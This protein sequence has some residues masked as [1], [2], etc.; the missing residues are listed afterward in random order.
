M[1]SSSLIKRAW[2]RTFK[3]RP[4][5]ALPDQ[6]LWWLGIDPRKVAKALRP[7]GIRS[8]TY[9]RNI[10]SEP[11]E[12]PAW[13]PS[14]DDALR[15]VISIESESVESQVIDAYPSVAASWRHEISRIAGAIE[16]VLDEVKPEI[17]LLVQ[18]Y[19]PANAIARSWAIRNECR[20]V[21]I[22]NTALQT[23]MVW[24]DVSGITTNRN[25]AANLFWRYKGYLTEGEEERFRGQVLAKVRD[26]K[27]D[28]HTAPRSQIAGLSRQ[29][30][31]LFLAQ[32]YTDSSVVF[33]LAEWEDPLQ[34][35]SAL[36]DWCREREFGLVIKLHPKECVGEDPILRRPYRQLTLRKM[37]S[38]PGLME[39]LT[40]DSVLIDSDNSFDTY[41][42]ID[43]SA[44]VVTINSQSGLE[45][46]MRGKAVV[47]CGRCFYG[48]LGFTLDAPSP[49]L[50]PVRLEQAVEG[51]DVSSAVAF[52]LVFYEKYCVERSEKG[53]VELVRK[54]LGG[55]A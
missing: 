35:V 51:V 3:R 1:G 28:E 48:G 54:R 46:A 21:A 4:V 20:L 39:R 11:R 17:V 43:Q 7:L 49:R 24:D 12:L 19:E 13:R 15:Y 5:I 45:A 23:R 31:I 27:S 26:L 50:L 30:Y 41:D 9:G 2:N 44:F 36:A 34:V 55:E 33:G 6:Q 53:L 22:E 14:W 18:G 52:G 40:S 37:K 42:L 8:V 25:L 29:P 47:V 32:V 38:T 10:A 16:A